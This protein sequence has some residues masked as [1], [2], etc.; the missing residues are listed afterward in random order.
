MFVFKFVH[1]KTRNLNHNRLLTPSMLY[2]YIDYKDLLSCLR[3]FGTSVE[4]RPIYG[5]V[6]GAGKNRI[7]MWSQ[8][9]G[10]ESTTTKSLIDFWSYLNTVQ[11]KF[12]LNECTFLMIP[13]LNPDG[14]EAYTRLNANKIDLNRDFNDLSQPESRLLKEIFDDFKPNYCF[15]LHGQ[16]TIFSA[17]NTSIPAT[18]SFLAPSADPEK[19]LT[20]AREM[21]MKLI[22]ATKNKL[23]SYLP[24]AIGRYDDAF[25]I[26][27]AGDYFTFQGTPTV[28]F[29]AGH[30]PEDYQRI[31]SRKAVFDSIIQMCEVI[32]LKK[33]H[34]FSI[35]DYF[36]IPENHKNLR[37]IEIF[38]LKGT[39]KGISSSKNKV[40]VQ[41]IEK[42]K[43]GK[44]VL[45]PCFDSFNEELIGL[46]KINAENH[47]YLKGV[48]VNFDEIKN[49]TKMISLLSLHQ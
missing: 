4:K 20:S 29:E 15:N 7:L 45:L 44:V 17:G 38:N 37:D 40:F 23:Q 41:Y 8:M 19:S 26:K 16:R 10:N 30:Y 33:I 13:Q 6:V 28:L 5:Y 36:E 35:A 25:N 47:P 32:S 22:V 9:H 2:D 18:I 12:M 42:K 3:T 14:S 1:M 43:E 11:A 27:C 31:K 24:N 34:S 48:S 21:A 46:N 39:S 49:I